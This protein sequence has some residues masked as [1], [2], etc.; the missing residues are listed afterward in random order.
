[1]AEHGEDIFRREYMCDF[2]D[3]GAEV[4]DRDLLAKAM[5]DGPKQLEI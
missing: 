3:S 1:M 2:L 4:F 5:D